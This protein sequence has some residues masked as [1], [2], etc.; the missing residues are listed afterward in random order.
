MIA[1][2][3]GMGDNPRPA[4]YGANYTAFAAHATL[5]H[6]A[7]P[8]TVVGRFCESGD[9]LSRDVLLPRMARGDVLCIPVSGAYHLS[10]SSSY[11]LVPQPAAVMVANGE[12]HLLTRRA[13][14][15]DLLAR[16]VFPR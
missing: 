11:N 15:D 16:E 14:V 3:G 6:D 5:G 8:S 1:V 4:L 2:D 7:V 13:T 12:A 10:M 9:V